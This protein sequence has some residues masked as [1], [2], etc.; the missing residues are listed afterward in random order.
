MFKHIEYLTGMLKAHDCLTAI[1]SCCGLAE[2]FRGDSLAQNIASELK[3]FDQAL[4]HA[5]QV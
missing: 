3:Q 4:V 2:H 5:F 1:E